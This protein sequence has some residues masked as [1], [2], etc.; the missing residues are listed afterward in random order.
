MFKSASSFVTWTAESSKAAVVNRG[1]LK[2]PSK[3]QSIDFSCFC[4]TTSQKY[5]DPNHS[6]LKEMKQAKVGKQNPRGKQLSKRCIWKQKS[7]G[8]DA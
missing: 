1:G 2:S 3:I 8:C 7:E 6:Q 5:L 4:P